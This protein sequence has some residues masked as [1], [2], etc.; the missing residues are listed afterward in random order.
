MDRNL[1]TTLMI[2]NLEKLNISYSSLV[3]PSHYGQDLIF[4][5]VVNV[6]NQFQM[7]PRHD[8]WIIAKHI[9]KYLCVTIHHCLWYVGSEIQL[10]RYTKSNW[11]GSEI[12][13]RST[14]DGYFILGY[15]M[16]TW[17][18]K[19][20]DIVSLSSVEA[21]YIVAS[22]VWKGVVWLMKLLS[23]LF[24]EP[25]STTCIHCDNKRYIEL[26]KDLVFHV[27]T[28]NINNK[29]DHIRSM[30]RDGS[31]SYTIFL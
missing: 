29:Y 6:L 24:D 16:V 8:H 19:K 10:I 22:K 31:W 7:E 18:N 2:T 30:V 12:N 28:K 14:I 5:F 23:Y 3:V 21:E 25:L 17:I 11:G 13:G 4:F 20:K 26:K 9:L 27:R 1:M 15:S